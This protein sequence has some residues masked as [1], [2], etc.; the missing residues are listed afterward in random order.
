MH[1]G[2][3]WNFQVATVQCWTMVPKNMSAM[4]INQ[5]WGKV[6][7]HWVS[8]IPISGYNFYCGRSRIQYYNAHQ[9]ASHWLIHSHIHSLAHSISHALTHFLSHTHTFKLSLTHSHILTFLLTHPSHPSVTNTHSQ[10][11]PPTP[12]H[13]TKSHTSHTLNQSSSPIALILYISVI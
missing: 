5:H 10:I 13:T 11:L 3:I 12:P 2:R 1:L 8:L 9:S 4:C 6:L 7:S